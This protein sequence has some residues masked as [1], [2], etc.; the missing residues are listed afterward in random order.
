MSVVIVKCYA[1][2]SFSKPIDKSAINKVFSFMAMEIFL[3]KDSRDEEFTRTQIR[4]AFCG[5][6]ITL[7]ESVKSV[8]D[9]DKLHYRL[10]SDC[11]FLRGNNNLPEKKF[12]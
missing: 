10:K 5:V 11:P 12:V 1:L 9:V 3:T 2:L 4:C 7:T 6:T 8:K